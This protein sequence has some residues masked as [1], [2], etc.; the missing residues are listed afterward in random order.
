MNKTCNICY[1]EKPIEEFYIQKN[2]PMCRCKECQRMYARKWHQLNK[3]K[4]METR[5]KFHNSKYRTKKMAEKEALEFKGD[6][7]IPK[8]T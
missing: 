2:N 7:T 1:E 8:A 3:L 6:T 5:A 4:M